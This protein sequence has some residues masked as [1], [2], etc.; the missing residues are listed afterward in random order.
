MLFLV[1][2]SPFSLLLAWR[3]GILLRMFELE[4]EDE[5]EAESIGEYKL[6]PEEGVGGRV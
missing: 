5:E 4:P 1:L 3:P 2:L 6:D